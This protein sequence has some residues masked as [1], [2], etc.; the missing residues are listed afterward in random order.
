MCVCV[1]VCVCVCGSILDLSLENRGQA[2]EVIHCLR[3]Q[4]LQLDADSSKPQPAA[5]QETRWA[6]TSLC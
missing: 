2:S 5:S 1:C 6:V 4:W 3:K